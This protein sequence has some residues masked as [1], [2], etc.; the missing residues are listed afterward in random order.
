[1]SCLHLPATAL[2]RCFG[3]LFPLLGLML[4]GCEHLNAGA[5]VPPI[6]GTSRNSADVKGAGGLAV[7]SGKT[8]N[9]L[10][11]EYASPVNLDLFRFPGDLDTEPTAYKKA[12]A[13]PDARNRLQDYVGRISD[14]VCNKHKADI[15][16]VSSTWNGGL[17]VMTTLFGGSNINESVFYNN[18]ATAIIRQIDAQRKQKMMDIVPKRSSALKDYSVDAALRDIAEYHNLCS[19]YEA[20]AA[21]ATDTK[22]PATADELKG[23]IESLRDQQDKNTARIGKLASPGNAN[24]IKVLNESNEAIARMLKALTTQL[25]LVE[26]APSVTPPADTPP[27]APPPAAHP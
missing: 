21:L 9:D 11:L 19:F 1:M 27:A 8:V 5:R 23:R 10:R 3:L 14:D 2:I 15:L 4:G 6:V 16:A 26:G 24:E 7:D 25:G 22:R 13:D 17:S 12:S 18:F 20:V